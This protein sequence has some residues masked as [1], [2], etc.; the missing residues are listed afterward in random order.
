MTNR[1]TQQ[2]TALVLAVMATVSVLSGLDVLAASENDAAQ[3]R[4][5]QVAVGQPG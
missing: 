4:T 5:A 1:I 2:A 3:V